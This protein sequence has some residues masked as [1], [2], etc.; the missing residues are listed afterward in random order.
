MT[1]GRA[2]ALVWRSTDVP[3]GA[4]VYAAVPPEMPAQRLG[5][6]ASGD[7][8]QP[9]GAA[10]ADGSTWVIASRSGPSR[11]RLWA[12]QFDGARWLATERGPSAGQY[13]RHP[14]LASGGEAMWAVWIASEDVGSSGR[15]GLY[16]SR[17][18]G[19]GWTAPERLPQ[20]SG[21]PMAPAIAVDDGGLPA[22]AWAADDGGHAEIWVSW[23]GPAGWSNPRALTDDETPD[24]SPSIAVSGD[25]WV[26]A[27]SSFRQH[28]YWTEA[29]VG[30]P[31]RGWETP[32]RISRRAGSSPVALASE[33]QL[34][35]VWVEP[36]NSPASTRSIL[37]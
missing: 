37:R 36:E 32:R 5:P 24:V 4:G 14:A 16:A 1:T 34:S 29:A 25:R 19:D 33:G 9:A 7:D 3:V 8:G 18:A 13:N 6:A 31:R 28:S 21:E 35:L 30:H 15:A 20:P 23:R 22:V 17:R 12:Q 2:A 27:W 11:S 26:I 10:R